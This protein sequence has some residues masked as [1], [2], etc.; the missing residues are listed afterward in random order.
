MPVLPGDFV[1]DAATSLVLDGIHDLLLQTGSFPLQGSSS[2]SSCSCSDCLWMILRSDLLEL[3]LFDVCG[4][5]CLKL[6]RFRRPEIRL[7]QE[8]CRLVP[9]DHIARSWCKSAWRFSQPFGATK[10]W[11]LNEE[12]QSCRS[13]AA[14]CPAW[15]TT[16]KRLFCLDLELHG[17]R[18]LSKCTLA[19]HLPGQYQQHLNCVEG[20]RRDLMIYTFPTY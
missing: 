15:S 6:S 19:R 18:S 10:P 2:S 9:G 20:I 4:H 13:F 14:I 11:E 17:G 5:W 1:I 16:R 12:R 7:I 3:F 8:L